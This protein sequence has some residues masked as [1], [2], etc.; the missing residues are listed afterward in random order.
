MMFS[1]ELLAACFEM[2]RHGQHFPSPWSALS[3]QDTP[4]EYKMVLFSPILTDFR[5]VCC[6]GLAF[7]KHSISQSSDN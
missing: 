7:S 3:V 4:F 6:L 5:M 2:P 1:R